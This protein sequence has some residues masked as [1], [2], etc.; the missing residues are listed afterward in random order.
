M[1][2]P[3]ASVFIDAYAVPWVTPVAG[4]GSA[5]ARL[6]PHGLSQSSRARTGALRAGPNGR[7][8]PVRPGVVATLHFPGPDAVPE[9]PRVTTSVPPDT[10]RLLAR[11]FALEAQLAGSVTAV[12][13]ALREDGFWDS[14][15]LVVARHLNEYFGGDARYAAFP[16][17]SQEPLETAAA[18]VAALFGARV[19]WARR[20]S[21]EPPSRLV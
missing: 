15:L 8:A 21:E 9:P 18:A 14:G 5:T 7:H 6:V 10:V 11:V 12:T 4:T 2:S 1:P 20:S 19:T 3:T 16:W 17:L 13:A